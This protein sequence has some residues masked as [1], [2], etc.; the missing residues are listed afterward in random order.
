MS[1]NIPQKS[2]HQE[3]DDS[4]DLVLD[5]LRERI[6]AQSD[7]V[8]ILDTKANSIMSIATTLLGT[9]FILQAALIA[10]SSSRAIA[11]DLIHLQGIVFV[12]LIIYL[13]T[14]IAATISGFWLRKFSR[15]PEPERLKDYALKSKAT[16]KSF[17]VGTITEAFNKNERIITSKV[18]GMR[19][20][21]LGLFG[22]IIT[23]G[24]LLFM[25][26]HG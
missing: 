10:I 24:V 9:A 7:R 21:T 6:T 26:I 16:T 5:L 4:Y 19:I 1:K 14:M 20:A 13:I 25:Q 12:L 22:E 17:L 15:A 11:L 3:Y 18:W 8:S 2:S 23:L